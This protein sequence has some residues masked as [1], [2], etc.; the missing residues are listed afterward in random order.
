[1]RLV[2]RLMCAV[3][4]HGLMDGIHPICQTS[5]DVAT[6]PAAGASVAKGVRVRLKAIAEPLLRS[7]SYRARRPPERAKSVALPSLHGLMVKSSL[8]KACA[9]CLLVSIP[10]AL[11]QSSNPGICADESGRRP[12]SP[13]DRRASCCCDP[14]PF[15]ALLVLA[16]VVWHRLARRSLPA[17]RNYHRLPCP[18]STFEK[19]SDSCSPSLPR[20]TH[21]TRQSLQPRNALRP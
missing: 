11:P 13:T 16:P 14:W 3:V 5:P 1:M 2:A 10:R 6:K 8:C 18:C 4:C 19:L 17:S 7:C 15:L 9:V 21:A 20:A 12:M